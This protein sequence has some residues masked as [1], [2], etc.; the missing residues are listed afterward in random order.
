MSNIV[1]AYFYGNNVARP[2]SLFQYDSGMKLEFVGITLPASFRVDFANSTTGVSKPMVGTNNVVPI[3][4]EFCVPGTSIYAWVVVPNDGG[5]NT[6][7]HAVI[8]V[9]ARAIPTDEEPT[10]E[11][12]SYIDQAIQ[13]MN[14]LVEETSAAMQ[15]YP[16]IENGYWYVWDITNEEYITTNIQAQGPQG[17]QGPQGPQGVQGVQGV[18]GPRGEQ[19]PKGDTGATGERGAQGLKGETGVQGPQGP[20]GDTGER[21]PQGIQGEKGEKGDTGEQGPQGA[22]GDTGEQGP[23]GT[24]IIATSYDIKIGINDNAAISAFKASEA[25]FYGLARAA[26]DSTQSASLNDVGAYTDNAKA[27]IRQMIN[28]PGNYVLVSDITLTSDRKYSHGMLLMPLSWPAKQ[29]FVYVTATS[30]TGTTSLVV[31]L[32]DLTRIAMHKDVFNSQISTT[33]KNTLVEYTLLGDYVIRD[34][35][36]D[37]LNSQVCRGIAKLSTS[38]E[39]DGIYYVGI[40]LYNAN[41]VLPIGTTIKVFAR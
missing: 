41:A 29:I 35:N 38:A 28:T 4:Y 36:L 3:P 8:T 30:S 40:G 6:V 25:V 1:K 37:N 16:I 34:Y 24:Q 18:Q 26:G 20:K 7:Y 9:D 14:G 32:Y 10:P 33:E 15:H 21:G 27:K 22:K 19:G 17:I 31:G 2:A 13:T 12:Q 5:R 39:H 23:P 11:Q